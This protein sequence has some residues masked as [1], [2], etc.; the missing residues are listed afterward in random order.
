MESPSMVA[1]RQ[2]DV[3]GTTSMASSITNRHSAGLVPAEGRREVWLLTE[4]DDEAAEQQRAADVEEGDHVGDNDRAEHRRDAPECCQR[5]L[6]QQ[7]HHEQEDEKPARPPQ[8]EQIRPVSSRRLK[9]L[10]PKNPWPELVPN[11]KPYTLKNP[12]PQNLTCSPAAPGQP[13][14]SRRRSRRR[15]RSANMGCAAA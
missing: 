5:C 11:H 13:A 12:K 14:S 10:N 1:D 4:W 7:Q 3:W 2:T 15:R 8:H 6:V 9:T